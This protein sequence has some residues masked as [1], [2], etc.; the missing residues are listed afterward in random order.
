M[1]TYP[2]VPSL[3]VGGVGVW[4]EGAVGAI[5]GWG[6]INSDGRATP[7]LMA[8]EVPLMAPE[9]CQGPYPDVDAEGLLCAGDLTGPAISAG[10][11][12]KPF[13]T[14][15]LTAGA[16]RTDRIFDEAR[17]TADPVRLMRLFGLANVTATEYV[18]TAHPDRRPAPT[19]A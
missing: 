9:T 19:W 3:V 14:I 4:E 8:A 16:V 10:L 18:L 17:H 2:P 15:G 5:A 1:A 11:L 6:D 7:H 12:R 13:R